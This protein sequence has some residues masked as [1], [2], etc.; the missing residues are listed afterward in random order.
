[1]RLTLS[2]F[3]KLAIVRIASGVER[4]ID[5]STVAFA[6]CGRFSGSVMAMSNYISPSKVGFGTTL[7]LTQEEQQLGFGFLQLSLF[8]GSLWN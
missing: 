5:L 7:L 4:S 3:H 1:M 8:I 2:D 6:N